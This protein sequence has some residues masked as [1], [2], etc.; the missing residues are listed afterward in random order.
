MALAFALAACGGP[1]APTAQSTPSAPPSPLPSPS[2]SSGLGWV[3]NL[4]FSG[5]LSGTMRVVTPN[6]GG[7]ESECSGKNSHSGG[8]WASTFY[9]LLGNQRYGV[10]FLSSEYRGPG[11]YS[12]SVA[13]AQ[14]FL[15]D[16]SKVWQSLGADS[17]TFTVNPDEESGQVDATLTNLANGQ[18]KLHMTGSWSCRT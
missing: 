5:D 17:V 14:V 10:S 7:Q 18:S 16:H 13:S 4:S 12:E 11:T 9:A 2:A 1:T 3:E 6:Q 15:P 8:N